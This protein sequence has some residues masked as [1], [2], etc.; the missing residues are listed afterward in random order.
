MKTI[1]LTIQLN[2]RTVRDARGIAEGAAEHLLETFD[3]DGSLKSIRHDVVQPGA[4][5]MSRLLTRKILAALR[6]WRAE[7]EEIL[8]NVVTN[9]EADSY[10]TRIQKIDALI[11]EVEGR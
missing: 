1:Q 6:E 5:T 4:R 9:E 8:S 2:V 7:C 11:E 3:D 10:D